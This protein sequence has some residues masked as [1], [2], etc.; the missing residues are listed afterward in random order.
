MRKGERDWID[1]DNR[2]RASGAR[3]HGP[4]RPPATSHEEYAPRS[5]LHNQAEDR[6]NVRCK[7][8]PGG[9]GLALIA[10]TLLVDNGTSRSGLKDRDGAEGSFAIVE[11]DH[12]AA[13]DKMRCEGAVISDN[14]P[15]NKSKGRGGQPRMMRSTG[16]TL[17]TQP[18][19]A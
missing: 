3:Q 17:A 2:D 1:I 11:P 6:V 9:I 19:T 15:F 14:R 7:A 12:V 18:T 13:L 5:R 4:K 16:M 8:D 10:A